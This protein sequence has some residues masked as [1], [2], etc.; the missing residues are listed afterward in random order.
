MGIKKT[1]SLKA[2][3]WKFLCML[4]LGLAASVILPFSLIFIGATTGFITYAD[5]SEQSAKS[6][7]P[8]I[9]ATPDLADVALPVGL[10][11]LVLDKNYQVLETSLKGDDFARAMDYAVAGKINEN[12]NKQ[13]LFITREKEYVVLQY[14]IGSQFTNEWFYVHFPS[15]EVLLVILIGIN[16]TA[17]CALLTAKFAKNLRAQLSPLFEATAQ[18]AQQNLDFEVGHS[19][20]R[21]F[22]DVLSSFSDMKDNLQASL[23]QQWNAEQ[24]QREQIAAL[25]HDLKTPLTVIQGNIDL[26]CETTLDEEQQLYAKYITES[27][28]QIGVYIRTLID[29]SR[30]AAGYQLHSE[31]FDL[32]DY[33]EQIAAR[34]DSLCLTQGISLRMETG[35]D[36]GT[37]AAD[38]LL[39]ERAI[40][41]VIGN[42][43]DYSPPGGTVYVMTQK[44]DDFLQISVTD[45]GSG[46]TPEALSHAREQFFMGEKSRTSKLHFGMGLFIT[47]SILQQHNGQLI[48]KNSVQTGGAVV[49]LSLPSP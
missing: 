18:V 23:K 48:L 31:A 28:E 47:D 12:L 39:L 11:Y 25:A 35:K 33:M 1:T 41:N 4:L 27:S 30:T 34:A 14:Y 9:A 49:I 32:S 42:A 6:L 17:V 10:K 3:F 22:E 19:M 16:C 7:V 21:E 43:L 37:L 44:V 40:F 46:F 24:L 2:S 8:V 5:Y 36:L 26:I 20:I 29:I 38:K 13:Y 45:E 15:P